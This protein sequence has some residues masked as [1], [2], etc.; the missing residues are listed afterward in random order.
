MAEPPLSSSGATVE[1]KTSAQS[2][3]VADKASYDDAQITWDGRQLKDDDIITVIKMDSPENAEY[4][5]FSLEP[6]D[7]SEPTPPTPFKLVKTSIPDLPEQ[8]LDRHLFKSLPAHL[9]HD[10]NI[11]HVLISTLSGTGLSPQ[12]FGDILETLLSAIGLKS[13]DYKV[14]STQS[15]ESVGEFARAELLL[16]ANEGKKQSVLM[17]SGDGGMVDTINGLLESGE[18]SRYVPIPLLY[19]K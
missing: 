11:I 17:L 8:F 6:A 7:A 2:A 16:R 18:R 3:Q 15:A 4:T 5:I 19:C 9:S 12:F 13:S 10:E 14:T 1:S